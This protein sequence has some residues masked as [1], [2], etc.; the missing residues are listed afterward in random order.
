MLIGAL[1]PFVTPVFVKPSTV[2]YEAAEPL[3]FSGGN[4]G[5]FILIYRNTREHRKDSI[6]Q[7]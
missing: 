7:N 3:L 4:L 2:G 1:Q 5:E 6:P